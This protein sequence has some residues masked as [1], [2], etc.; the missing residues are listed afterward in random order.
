MF[1]LRRWIV[2]LTLLA[3]AGGLVAAQTLDRSQRA[4]IRFLQGMIDHHQ[5]ALDMAL[6]CL[7]RAS[8]DEVR[9]ICEAVIA[10]QT[11]EIEQMQA[12]LLE[13]YNIAYTPM[14][15]ASMGMM[16]MPAQ[17]PA[18]GGHGEHGSHGSSANQPFTDPP[19]M[20]GMMA[21]F[22][23]YTGLDYDIAWL[24]SMIDHHDDALHMAER[25]LGRVVQAELGTLAQ[26]IIN[27]QSAEIELMETLI[28]TLEAQ[29]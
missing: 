18:Q 5:M 24:E 29:R 21:G 12:W 26:A 7:E 13:W 27:D 11:P 20:M 25:I 17:A 9:A 14:P 23:R 16:D 4:E 1:M 22:N 8:T 3:L 2:T 28:S 15:M 6:D 19:M 10:A